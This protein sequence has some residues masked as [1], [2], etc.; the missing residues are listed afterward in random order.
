MSVAIIVSYSANNRDVFEQS[1]PNHRDYS[2]RHGYELVNIDEPYNC[3]V[4]TARVRDCLG[5][6]SLVVCMGTDIIIRRPEIPLE[7]FARDG[8]AMCPEHGNGTL[9]GDLVLFSRGRATG[10]V[11]DALDVLQRQFRHGQEAINH[12]YRRGCR[13]I[14]S[15]GK[16]QI[17]A[18]AMNP[19][20]DYSGVDL[21]EYFALHYHQM[22]IAPI[23]AAKAAAMRKELN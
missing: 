16:M 5:R 6:Y 18:P 11:L 3:Y 14:H 23:P 13:G 12:L 1:L 8:V 21:R 20:V 10:E 15:V 4:D 19:G 17:A 7:F 9:N 22:G 2:A